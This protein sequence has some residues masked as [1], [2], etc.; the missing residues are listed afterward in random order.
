[1]TRFERGVWSRAAAAAPE[2]DSQE[3]EKPGAERQREERQ[4]EGMQGE[5]FG[6]RA[7]ERREAER[8]G[9]E[10]G[11]MEAGRREARER[12]GGMQGVVVNRGRGNIVIPTGKVALA[13]LPPSRRS[14]LT[15]DCC[16]CA[17]PAGACVPFFLHIPLRGCLLSG[18]LLFLL[19]PYRFARARGARGAL[20]S[21]PHH[22]ALRVRSS[23]CSTCSG[24]SWRSFPAKYPHHCLTLSHPW[25]PI[26][27]VI[28]LPSLLVSP[29]FPHHTERWQYVQRQLAIIRSQ[30]PPP[31][32]KSPPA[33]PQLAWQK[34]AP[35]ASASVNGRVFEAAETRLGRDSTPEVS[36]FRNLGLLRPEQ[37]ALII[38][39]TG[40][41]ATLITGQ[42]DALNLDKGGEEQRTDEW[43][44]LRAN[45]LTASAFEKAV[46][47][48]PGGRQQLWEEKLGL[49]AP[50]AGNEATAW[51]QGKEEE[52]L[53]EYARM[54]GGYV[55]HRAFQG[56]EE[57]A[58]REYERLTG[59]HV[60]HRAFQVGLRGA[61]RPL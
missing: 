1:M 36:P 51:G 45:R 43:Y 60:E 59:G 47:L 9:T 34:A 15:I 7:D 61:E 40:N 32:L 5:G 33:P 41:A 50:F 35:P 55:E 19:F 22:R 17:I 3:E 12:T 28:L 21:S 6:V 27:L 26:H 18:C 46:G 2:E 42:Q 37:P 49:R 20:H 57:E 30:I 8:D 16:A 14:G 48:F 4:G 54:T 10:A 23:P 52:A 24:S 31:T 11:R 13:F 56:R 29:D 53:R 39:P 25:S 58:L 38:P 44:A